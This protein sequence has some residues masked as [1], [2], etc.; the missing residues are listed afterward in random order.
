MIGFAAY[1]LTQLQTDTL[2]GAAPGER[3]PER[4][5]QRNGHRGRDWQTQAGNVELRIPKLRRGSCFPAFLEPRRT[6]K[7][8][9]AAVIQEACIRGASTR[10]VDGLSR[11]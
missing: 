1:R 8:A 6:A 9:L 10:S 11:P 4:P 2:C 3:S 5:N 7:K